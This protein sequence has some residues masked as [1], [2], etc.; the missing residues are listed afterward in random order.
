[1]KPQF[2]AFLAAGM[3][4]AVAAQAA[5]VNV[6]S[7]RHYKGDQQVFANFTRETGIKVNVVEGDINGLIQRLRREGQSSPADLMIT[8]DAGN[9][10]RLQTAGLTQPVK[11]AALEEVVPAALREPGGN[12]YAISQR[13]RI[14][15][16]HM[17]RV[18]PAD[19]STY[20]ALADPKLKGK[21]L[22]RSSNQVYNQSLLA[23]MI[24]ANGVEK[25]E[26]WARGLVANFARVPQ[27]GD[28]DQITAL[29]AGQGDVAIVNTY[30]IGRLKGGT[31]EERKLVEKIG[32]FFPNQSDRGTHVNISG[33]A[34][35]RHA[36]NKD[37]AVKLMEY[38]VKPE[39]QQLIAEGNF[40]Y[41]VSPDVAVAPAIA[42]WGKFKADT[43]A[44]AALGQHNPEA[45]RLADRAGWR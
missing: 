41:P 4:G 20:E 3:V 40:E 8:V 25:T 16:Y 1:M 2:L 19:L 11:S 43:L 30:Y 23:S 14:I 44:L 9:L 18:K 26:A 28:L 45:V 42:A 29:V 35:T 21:V 7:S 10:W 6:Y 17:D 39:S 22:V 27:G 13:A 38:L 36:P 33:V 34:L 32:A 15:A 31:P 12:W 24:A 37:D 5:E